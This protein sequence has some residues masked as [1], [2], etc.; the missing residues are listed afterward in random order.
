MRPAQHVCRTC[1]RSDVY[2]QMNGQRP[3]AECEHC[4]AAARMKPETR[5]YFER[6]WRK[7]HPQIAKLRK[8][9]AL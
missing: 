9:G 2:F 4:R 1:G 3:A 5:R 8:D 7:L 6:T